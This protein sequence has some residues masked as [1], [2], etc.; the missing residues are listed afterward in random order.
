MIEVHNY[1]EKTKRNAEEILKFL[2]NKN[3]KLIYGTYPG[4]CIFKQLI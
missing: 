2:T 3:F 1:D 4:N